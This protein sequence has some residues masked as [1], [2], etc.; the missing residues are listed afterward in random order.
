MA[1]MSTVVWWWDS[2]FSLL[3]E[4][5][6]TCQRRQRSRE[7]RVERS[8]QV[9]YKSRDRNFG[10]KVLTLLTNPKVQFPPSIEN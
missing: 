7:R 3:E 6:E 1:D 5:S 2:L 10:G 8:E 9:L 4:E